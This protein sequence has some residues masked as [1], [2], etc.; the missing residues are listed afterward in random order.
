MWEKKWGWVRNVGLFLSLLTEFGCVTAVQLVLENS[1]RL[2]SYVK[3]FYG[4]RSGCA[5]VYTSKA[6]DCGIGSDW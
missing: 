4:A 5:M 2:V 6:N 1:H 3:G